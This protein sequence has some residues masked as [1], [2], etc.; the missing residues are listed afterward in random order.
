[1]LDGS[2]P[3]TPYDATGYINT[4]HDEQ[5]SR[6]NEAGTG[7]PV[8][9]NAYGEETYKGGAEKAGDVEAFKKMCTRCKSSSKYFDQRNEIDRQAA[10]Y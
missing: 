6:K 7:L 4:R 3:L 10:S 5:S 9:L 1:M 8:T 2:A